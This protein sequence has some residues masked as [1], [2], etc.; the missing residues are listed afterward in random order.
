MA[1]TSGKAAR[2]IA[3]CLICAAGTALAKDEAKNPVVKERIALM[4]T[5]RMNT[6]KLGDMASGKAAFDA[7][8]AASAK[9]ALVAAAGQIP[10]KFKPEE[11][12]PVS[13]AK[14]GIWQ[15]WDDF[16]KHAGALEAAAGKIDTAS[17]DGVKAG[18]G[19]VGQACKSCHTTYR[20]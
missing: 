16:A 7:A 12:D 13:E 3:L 18:M 1:L 2:A 15:D 20:Q 14:P 6:G 5:I 4:Q 10:A 8:G 9:A 11:T 19:G 17:L